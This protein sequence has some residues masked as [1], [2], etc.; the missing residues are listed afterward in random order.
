[1]KKITQDTLE[2]IAKQ[3]ETKSCVKQKAYRNLC[4]IF[5]KME[6]ETK[7][8]IEQINNKV[9]LNDHEV[10]IKFKKINEQEFH[11]K[12]AGDL[13]VFIMHTNII[14]MDKNHAL[15]SSPAIQEDLQRKYLGQIMVYNFMADSFKYHRLKDPGYLVARFLINYQEHFFIEGD[16][17][18]S[19]LFKD[20]SDQP[21]DATDIHVFIQLAIANAIDKDLVAPPFPEIR[22][23]TVMQK[24]EK[25]QDLGPGQKIGFQMAYQ[26]SI[27]S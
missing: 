14:T 21:V 23:I 2:R 26:E 1:M 11:L 5:K 19:F 27:R 18:L 17:Q 25:T 4:K 13:L 24:M 9:Q 20:L 7:D 16:G 3:L 15:N 8:V 12:V 6:L 10:T 22:K